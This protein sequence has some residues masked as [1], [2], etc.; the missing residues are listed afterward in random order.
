MDSQQTITRL[1][2]ESCQKY[3][4]NPVYT[5]LGFTITFR[6]LDALTKSFATYLQNKT[7]LK[8]GDRIA[9]QLPNLL[10]YPV[11]AFGA[12]R[13]GLVIVNTNPLYTEDE[14]EHQLTD[15]GAKALVV[16]ENFADIATKILKKTNVEVVITTQVGDMHSTWKRLLINT[17]IKLKGQVKSFSIPDRVLLPDIL[18]ATEQGPFTPVSAKPE[19]LAVLQY[20][21][22]TT[23]IAKGA[24]LSHS[25]LVSNTRQIHAHLPEVFREGQETY[26]AP[27]PLYHIYAFTMHL[28]CSLSSGNHSVLIPNPRDIG[29]IVKVFKA[30]PLTGFVGL[31][32]L[33]NALLENRNFQKLDFSHL[34]Y[35]A[36]GGMAMTLD[37]S[38]RWQ[39]LTGCEISEGYGLTET[40]PVV[41]SNQYHKTKVG[42]IGT[43][44]PET[45]VKLIKEGDAE[46]GELLV[47]GP[48]VM[49]GYWNRPDETNNVLTEDGWLHTGDVAVIEEGGYIRIVDRIKDMIIVSGFKVFPNE[50]EDV[51]SLHP[52]ISECAAI[53]VEDE[54]S[55]EVVKVFVVLK[56][57]A[58]T[59]TD[60]KH[61]CREKFTGYKVPKYIEIRSQLPKSNVG[62]ILRRVL[63]EETKE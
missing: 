25:N 4:D 40:S 56:D 36:A 12:L 28:L 45:Q 1:F 60:I 58:L 21:G 54:H 24:M 32:T 44:V 19:D 26:G 16:L 31:N 41:S 22:G 33:Y 46:S 34:R 17:V 50:I 3:A 7:N 14:L 35:C 38:T 48:Q 61:F 20:T 59:V 57:P 62:K 10:Q 42:T 49:M 47:K 9:I 13:A 30:H 43:L 5:A 6:E 15:A 39:A 63:K 53:G 51:I 11:V 55:G 2:E 23:G 27:L 8:P 18:K 29:S 52:G 37:T